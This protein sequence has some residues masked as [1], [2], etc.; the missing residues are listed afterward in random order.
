MMDLSIQYFQNILQHYGGLG[1]FFLLAL[2]VFGLPIPDETILVFTGFLIAKGNLPIVTIIWAY[3][4]SVIGVT[5]S[6]LLGL[7]VG[8]NV[9]VRFG[10]YIGI[11]HKKLEK[12]HAWYER[13][14]KWSLL[15][16]Y[17][18]PGIRHLFGFFAG[19]AY[20]S[21]W[22]FALYAYTGGLIWTATFLSI[23]Y[24]FYHQWVHW[25]LPSYLFYP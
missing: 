15:I 8:K 22:R 6:Y 7:L 4:G 19:S 13:I 2:G 16:G 24:F 25:N 11:T 23:G 10:R 9:L 1:L 12:A 3:A 17:Y 18:I 5:A 21:Y 20:L 14:G